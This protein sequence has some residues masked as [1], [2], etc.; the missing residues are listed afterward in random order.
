M[1]GYL[2]IEVAE[3]EWQCI[4]EDVIAELRDEWGGSDRAWIER[5]FRPLTDV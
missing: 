3:G 1:N 2:W 4:D 5:H